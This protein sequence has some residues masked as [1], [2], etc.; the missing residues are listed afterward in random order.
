MIIMTPNFLSFPFI[1]ERYYT[2][3]FCFVRSLFRS[4]SVVLHNLWKL[5]LF[6]AWCR[7]LFEN[8]SLGLS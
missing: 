4:Y 8:V 3:R 7:V 1:W 5:H 2:S 6:T